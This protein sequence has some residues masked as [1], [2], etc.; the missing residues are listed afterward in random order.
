MME[1]TIERI[2]LVKRPVYGK[3]G[4]GSLLEMVDQIALFLVLDIHPLLKPVT[5]PG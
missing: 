5:R 1:V 3:E 4:T 2:P